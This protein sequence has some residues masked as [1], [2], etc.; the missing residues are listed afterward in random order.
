MVSIIEGGL[1]SV[2]G[3]RA[4]GVEAGIKHGGLDLLLLS[5]DKGPI[6]AAALFTSNLVKGSPLQITKEHLQNGKLGAVVANSGCANA[7][8][9]QQGIQ[10]AR[11]T[12]ELVAELLDINPGDVGVASTGLIGTRL[13]M[14]QI[15]EGIKKA[16][17][18]LSNSWE[19][20]T[21]AA[22]AIMTTD[23]CPKEI[24]IELE[25]E[26]GTRT[27]IGGATKGAGMIH[28]DLHATML[29]FI[30]T[31]ASM[32]PAG[33]RSALQR[34]ADNSFNM[35]S[36]DRDTS[37]NDMALAMA[38]GLAKNDRI[39]KK[40]PSKKF[41][42]GLDFVTTE[43]ARMIARDGEGATHLLEVHVEGAESRKDARIAARAVV[44]SNLVKAAVFGEDPNWG[45]IVAA[46]GYSGASFDPSK[47]SISFKSEEGESL[48]LFRGKTTS[49]ENLIRAE[50]V[51]GEEK[52]EIHIDLGAGQESST[53]WGCDLSKEYVEINSKYIT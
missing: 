11:E 18:Q 37:T 4:T 21:K 36:I 1:T 51:M 30:V 28:P 45:R 47:L 16:V 46:L 23:T 2:P 17:K 40:H 27:T 48:I 31:D 26:D 5:S 35:V 12:A 24:A 6:P 15:R 49:E 20:G 33:L 43:L 14:N 52:I 8:T 10:D 50:E 34:S 42:K 13:P 32:T 53:A 41:Q 29:A 7:Y 44:G 38:N 22:K 39:T 25:L 19:D 9:G 3:F